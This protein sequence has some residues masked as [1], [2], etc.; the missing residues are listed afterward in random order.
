MMDRESRGPWISYP[1]DDGSE[2]PEIR[3]RKAKAYAD[4]VTRR[5]EAAAVRIVSERDR[6]N[7][8]WRNLWGWL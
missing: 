4:E 3:A 7:R 5:C 2:A 1:G 6:A 8:S